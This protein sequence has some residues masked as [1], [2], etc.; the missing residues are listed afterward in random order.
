MTF[1]MIKS[2]QL[3]QIEQ[4]AKQ[5]LLVLSA[6]EVGDQAIF[7]DLTVLAIETHHEQQLRS[8]ADA[9]EQAKDATH[10][11]NTWESEGGNTGVALV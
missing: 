3:N 10:H 1:K 7:Q 4:L 2:K 6:S 9:N 11:L 5:L 8:T